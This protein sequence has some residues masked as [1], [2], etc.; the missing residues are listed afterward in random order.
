MTPPQEKSSPAVC[1]EQLAALLASRFPSAR[2]RQDG[3][4]RVV[5]EQP[6]EGDVELD[7]LDLPLQ[8]QHLLGP[9]AEFRSDAVRS[10]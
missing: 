1:G 10:S 5:S 3:R 4:G 9:T 6:S 8:R 2:R 7:L